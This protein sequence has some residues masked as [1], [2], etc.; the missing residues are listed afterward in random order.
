MMSNVCRDLFSFGIE[1]D[2]TAQYHGDL[3]EMSR[4]LGMVSDL[5]GGDRLLAAPDAVD[6]ISVVIGRFIKSDVRGVEL[7]L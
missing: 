6:K 2:F 1:M 5:T 3:S 4:Y 7:F